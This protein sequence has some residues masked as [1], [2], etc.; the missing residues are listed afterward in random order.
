[1]NPIPHRGL[2]VVGWAMVGVVATAV[3]G[4]AGLVVAARMYDEDEYR[5]RTPK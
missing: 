1:M 5:W 2:V 3:G 4:L